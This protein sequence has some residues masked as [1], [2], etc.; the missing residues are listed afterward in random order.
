MSEKCPVCDNISY[1][2]D[3]ETGEI[4]CQSCG[5]VHSTNVVNRGQDW[6][7][8]T[9]Q[10]RNEKPR[11]GP[12]L[13]LTIHDRGLSSSISGRNRDYSGRRIKP[14]KRSKFYRL[15]KW[16]KR[17]KIDSS[18][19][20]NLSKALGFLSKF[21]N[22][23][24]LPESVTQTAALVY[25]QV[26]KKDVTRGRTINDLVA[27]SLYIGCRI[28]GVSKSLAD[29]AEVANISKLEAARNYRFLYNI[30]DQDIP[31]ISTGKLISNIVK[32]LNLSGLVE[33]V[34]LDLLNAASEMKITSGKSPSGM[35]AACL[36]VGC[37][38][39]GEKITQHD[40][41]IKANVTEVTIRNRYKE[42]VNELDL[43]VYL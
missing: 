36:Y 19:Q 25:R 23:L 5:F 15:R 41:A 43:E 18:K 6:R 20:R 13:K 14:G 31:S 32:Q 38:V 33:R 40:L 29:I 26:L 34:S 39:A 37:K 11:A 30:V 10:E 2:Q 3:S 42:L 28:C 9:L 17:T 21:S 16:H 7:A 12:P 1:I 4:V 27:A 24:K 35:A 8:F 22:E